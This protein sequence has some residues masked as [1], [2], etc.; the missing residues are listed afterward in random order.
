METNIK[1]RAIKG[2]VLKDSVMYKKIAGSTIYLT[3][4]QLVISQEVGVVSRFMQEPRK[5]HLKA[6][7]RILRYVKGT[8]DYGL[9]YRKDKWKLIGY[10]DPNF[11]ED[12]TT[13]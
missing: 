9:L 4:T 6:L 5:P 13:H 12:P 11:V 1:L 3:L 8:S 10:C 7:H 2:D